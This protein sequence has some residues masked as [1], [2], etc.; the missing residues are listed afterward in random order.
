VQLR[1]ESEFRGL[2]P[3]PCFSMSCQLEQQDVMVS[4]HPEL[5]KKTNSTIGSEH[6]EKMHISNKE[7]LLNIHCP[8]DLYQHYTVEEF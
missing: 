7:E 2:C 6:I 1:T 8:D 3:L 4:T 5:D